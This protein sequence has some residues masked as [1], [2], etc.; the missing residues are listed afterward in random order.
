MNFFRYKLMQPTGE[1]ES[2]IISL[3]FEDV[4]SAVSYLERDGNT[5]IFVKKLGP[6][7]AVLFKMMKTSIRKKISRVFLAEFL[8]NIS[9]MLKAGIPIVTALEESAVNSA[10]PEFEND[11]KDMILSL[12][13]GASLSDVIQSNPHIFPKTVYHLIRI[14]ETSGT[15]DQR[16]KDAA[17]HLKRIQAIV[18]DTKQALLYPS[19]VFFAMGAGLIFW[20]YYV[21]PKIITLFDEMDVQLPALTIAIIRISEFIQ[22]EIFTIAAAAVIF[23]LLIVTL[24]RKNRSFR[25]LSDFILL[26]LPVVGALITASTLAFITEYFALLINAGI[27]ILQSMQIIQDSVKNKIFKEKLGAVKES[28]TRSEPIASSFS[29]AVIFP[30][31][32]CR[33]INIGEVS[34]T[35]PEQLQY[36]A[37]DYRNKLA[38][39]VSTLGKIIEPF[40]LIVAGVMFAI[41]IGGLFLPIY[42][43]IGRL[44]G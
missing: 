28:L 36:I 30:R 39:M 2:N 5:T 23:F 41:I 31:F 32:V 12:Q 33:M 10:H 7:S 27:D 38:V 40:V 6:V 3:P 18:S 21:V 17:D 13:G 35:L 24:Y 20:L 9:M 44:G 43:L 1:I 19:F 8:S 14:G 34:G 15:L 22:Q 37:E 4:M 42:D 11:V 26:K 25:K 29:A 16:L